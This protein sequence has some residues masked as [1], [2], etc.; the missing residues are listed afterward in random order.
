MKNFI[1]PL[2]VMLGILTS[3]V[4]WAQMTL[5]PNGN[6]QKSEVSQ[7]LGLVKVTIVYSSPDVA[8]REIW[9]KIVPYGLTEQNP[10]PWRAGANENTTIS[11]SHDVDV[12]GKPIKAGTYGLHMIPG[13]EEWT[14]IFSNNIVGMGKFFL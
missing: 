3:V 2:V 13:Q 5:P 4:S 8:G 11:F 10:L 12:E 9:G 14:I 6:N 1:K 7:Y